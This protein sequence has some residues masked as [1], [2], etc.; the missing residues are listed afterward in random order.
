KQQGVNDSTIKQHLPNNNTNKQQGVSNKSNIVCEQDPLNNLSIPYNNKENMNNPYNDKENI[1]NNNSSINNPYNIKENI[2]IPNIINNTD[3]KGKV[4]DNGNVYI[5]NL[6][7]CTCSC[8]KYQLLLIP[9][10]HAIYFIRSIGDNVLRHISCFYSEEFNRMVGYDI[11]PVVNEVV[12]VPCDKV[13]FNRKPGRP[14]RVRVEYI[15]IGKQGDQR[16][17]GLSKGVLV[18]DN[19]TNVYKGVS[20]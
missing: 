2:I 11:I 17:L 4:Y 20:Y 8:G 16:G 15:L 14:K 3:F 10:Y 13:Y 12:K 19:Y 5:V 1:N 6:K 9:C 18:I 7:E